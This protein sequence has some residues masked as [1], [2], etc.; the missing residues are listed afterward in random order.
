MEENHLSASESVSVSGTAFLLWDSNHSNHSNHSNNNID[1]RT[2]YSNSNSKSK[3]TSTCQNLPHK[4]RKADKHAP[5]HK[6]KARN[7]DKDPPTNALAPKFP[8]P[9][10]QKAHTSM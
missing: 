8:K 1:I 2:L 10:T 4:D 3:S 7:Q 6:C 5:T 9:Q